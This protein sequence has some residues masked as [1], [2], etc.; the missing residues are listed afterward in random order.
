MTKITMNELYL[1]RNIRHR[2]YL[3][4][5]EGSYANLYHVTKDWQKSN[6]DSLPVGLYLVTRREG[7]APDDVDYYGI[8]IDFVS[9]ASERAAYTN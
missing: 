3:T 4:G 1:G 9:R 2:L 7:K 6:T 8:V 5:S